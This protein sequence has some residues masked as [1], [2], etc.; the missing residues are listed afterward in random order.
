MPEAASAPVG[1]VWAAAIA[2]AKAGDVDAVALSKASVALI[3]SPLTAPV[4]LGVP[5]ITPLPALRNRPG[6]RLDSD[7]GE[8]FWMS[9]YV[10]APTPVVP[11]EAAGVEAKVTPTSPFTVPEGPPE[12]ASAGSTATEKACEVAVSPTALVTFTDRPLAAPR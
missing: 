4:A 10:T 8:P 11:T 5:L 3:A 7:A 1:A 2:I 9:A 12:A 6:H